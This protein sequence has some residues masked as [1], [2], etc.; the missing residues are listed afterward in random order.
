MRY[1]VP[2]I[3]FHFLLGISVACAQIPDQRPYVM[4]EAFDQKISRTIRFTIPTLGVE[5]LREQQDDVFL[6][7][8]REVEE[9]EVSHIE[10]AKF[11]GYKKPNYDLLEGL[12]KD[13][14]IVVYCSI[15]YRSEKIG[16]ELKKRGYTN[17]KNLYGSIFEWANQGY[18][19]VRGADQATRRIHTYNERWSKWVDGQKAEKVW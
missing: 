10:G 13:T 1:R 7:D 18:P 12:P 11:L 6:L 9:F 14:N 3:Y 5:E 19:M 17:V 4:D 8:A 15:G 2:V 16:E